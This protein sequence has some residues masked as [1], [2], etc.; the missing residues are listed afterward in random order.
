MCHFSNLY[1]HYILPHESFLI[2]F[3]LNTPHIEIILVAIK[4]LLFSLNLYPLSYFLNSPFKSYSQY[5][6]LGRRG[7]RRYQGGRGAG[8]GGSGQG[9]QRRGAGQNGGGHGDRQQTLA[10]LE[11]IIEYLVKD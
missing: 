11:R 6:Y 1:R 2:I 8:R 9:G 10:M 4:N 7:R 5:Y 3:S